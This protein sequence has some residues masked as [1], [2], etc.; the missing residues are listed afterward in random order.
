MANS[1]CIGGTRNLTRQ[2]R[3]RISTGPCPNRSSFYQG[4]CGCITENAGS[5]RS[6]AIFCSC[7]KVASM[8][9]RMT[10]TNH[11]PCSFCFHQAHRGKATSKPSRQRRPARSSLTKSG[12]TSASVTT[13]TFCERHPGLQSHAP[14]QVAKNPPVSCLA[15]LP[16]QF[17]IYHR[18]INTFILVTTSLLLRDLK[19]I[20]VRVKQL[21]TKSL[22]IVTF[23]LP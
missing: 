11:H 9:F 21:A 4:Q 5:T 1:G 8:A 20:S 13:T 6:Q 14:S 16:F 2:G 3:P 23:T 10:P 17:H 12:R 18:R 7:P 19:G 22:Y 15:T